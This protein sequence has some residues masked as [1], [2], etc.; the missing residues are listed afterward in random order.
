[1]ISS[2]ASAGIPP[3]SS[4]RPVQMGQGFSDGPRFEGLEVRALPRTF[5][6]MFPQAAKSESLVKFLTS[7]E[8]FYNFW[9]KVIAA[10]ISG[11]AILLAAFVKLKP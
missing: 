3:R 6:R 9:S 5:E 2:V 11:G 8:T 10:A 4:V 1:M 7:K